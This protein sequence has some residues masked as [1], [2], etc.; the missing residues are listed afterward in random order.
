MGTQIAEMLMRTLQKTQKKV[1]LRYI[2]EDRKAEIQ[3]IY[4]ESPEGK[5]PEKLEDWILELAQ[6]QA[7]YSPT[8]EEHMEMLKA[9]AETAKTPAEK[10]MA[11]M[12][13]E[14][15]QDQERA[16]LERR[17]V[18]LMEALDLTEEEASLPPME[19]E[20]LERNLAQLTEPEAQEPD[21]D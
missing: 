19:V 21:W 5:Y 7:G 14:N 11:L 8:M 17:Q 6:K 1:L 18:H 3:I 4:P 15:L 12:G 16:I 13:V 20:E 9:K 2:A 10:M